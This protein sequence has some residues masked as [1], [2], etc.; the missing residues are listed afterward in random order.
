ME[1]ALV[2]AGLTAK[3][4]CLAGFFMVLAGCAASKV[5]QPVSLRPLPEPVTKIALAP[6]GG[7]L[8]DAIGTE[9]FNHGFE[10]IDTQATS[11]FL[12]RSNLDEIEMLSPKSLAAL[13]GVGINAVLNVRTVGATT[14]GHR[15]QVCEWSAPQVVR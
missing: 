5:S 8:A 4:F 7:V 1:T 12:I 10:V 15:A 13:R 3:A 11:N 2:R 9:L 14:T 6:S